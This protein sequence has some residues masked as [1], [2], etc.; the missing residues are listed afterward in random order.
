MSSQN[1]NRTGSTSQAVNSSQGA[2]TQ[3]TYQSRQT[4]IKSYQSQNSRF[5]LNLKDV[6]QNLYIDESDDLIRNLSTTE[7]QI[8][9]QQQIQNQYSTLIVI[10]NSKQQTAFQDSVIKV[11]EQNLKINYEDQ[12]EK[13]YSFSSIF[14]NTKQLI[15]KQIVDAIN[16]KHDVFSIAY[17]QIEGKCKQIILPNMF[18]IIHE[19]GIKNKLQIKAE[20]HV[21]RPKDIKKLVILLDPSPQE[22]KA[23][24]QKLPKICVKI[25]HLLNQLQHKLIVLKLESPQN[26]LIV[27]KYLDVY[28]FTKSLTNKIM[29]NQCLQDLIE[30]AGDKNKISE[31]D[32]IENDIFSLRDMIVDFSSPETVQ[33]KTI[34]SQLVREELLK[35]QKICL[36]GFIQN[37]IQHFHENL[38]TLEFCSRFQYS[39]R[40]FD[41]LKQTS[42][43]EITER[44]FEDH[45]VQF[46]PQYP[47]DNNNDNQQSLS[48]RDN[49]FI[50]T[51]Q[52]LYEHHQHRQSGLAISSK[53][54]GIE[55]Q[56]EQLPNR[57]EKVRQSCSDD[58]SSQIISQQ[59]DFKFPDGSSKISKQ[60]LIIE[61]LSALSQSLQSSQQQNQF[62]EA[63]VLSNLQHQRQILAFDNQNQQQPKMSSKDPQVKI[64]FK[65]DNMNSL[66]PIRKSTKEIQ[67]SNSKASKQLLKRTVIDCENQN[68]NIQDSDI[69]SVPKRRL[70]FN[71][72]I[73]KN[74]QIIEKQLSNSEYEK[75][76]QSIVNE[77]IITQSLFSSSQIENKPESSNNNQNQQQLSSHVNQEEE[78][79]QSNQNNQNQDES[80]HLN[81]Q[82][83]EESQDQIQPRQLEYQLQIP[84]NEREQEVIAEFQDDIKD[85]TNNTS[86]DYHQAMLIIRQS[87]AQQSQFFGT[88][89]QFFL[90]PKEKTKKNQLLKCISCKSLKESQKGSVHR[91]ENYNSQ[92]V[93][94][95]Q[96]PR[97]G[98]SSNLSF[99]NRNLE[100]NSNIASNNQNKNLQE[101]RQ[102]MPEQ[103][104]IYFSNQTRRS[105]NSEMEQ[106]QHHMNT[107]RF[108]S[109]PQL[110]KPPIA[111]NCVK[112]KHHQQKSDFLASIQDN[113]NLNKVTQQNF[114]REQAIKN[115]SNQYI[116]KNQ[117]KTHLYNSDRKFKDDE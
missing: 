113:R 38:N 31:Q 60:M 24:L 51:H 52:Q 97:R 9:Q 92:Q 7:R 94:Q 69:K 71:N 112:L 15:R 23:A 64:K 46:N 75:M 76:Q 12:F 41:L 91:Y 82:S 101:I 104:Q 33:N 36:I 81:I 61:T 68:S 56:S 11:N 116:S 93:K 5:N 70:N 86:E 79:N 25:S 90:Q 105:R 2:N 55:M 20:F 19:M 59:S 6:G 30:Q 100:F 53:V 63:S 57:V 80:N 72:S 117:L 65:I 78:L 73:L 85:I 84:S 115:D 28:G 106:Y 37:S 14:S 18:D 32:L 114:M 66:S 47:T 108:T 48:K 74:V 98:S 42:D 1:F 95:I 109:L 4:L 50:P 3:Q 13:N 49:I 107:E 17:G 26:E 99:I 22:F 8:N 88:L 89:G 35:R 44:S 77:M 54:L 45:D 62:K 21:I 87:F 16:K 34:L 39:M 67:N 110:V 96:R 40:E 102:L 10:E 27:L 58:S 103:K 83:E 111:K 43:D 29:N